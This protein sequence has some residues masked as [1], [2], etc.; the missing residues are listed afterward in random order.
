MRK[1]KII[2]I[3]ILIIMIV[4]T[5]VCIGLNIIYRKNIS[6][7]EV[8]T[9]SESFEYM[10]TFNDND[11]TPIV[12]YNDNDNNCTY[13]RIST[14]QFCYKPIDKNYNDNKIINPNELIS[15]IYYKN[16]NAKICLNM[17][18]YQKSDPIKSGELEGE[19]TI[20][21]DYNAD[22]VAIYIKLNNIT[23]SKIELNIENQRSVASPS[24]P[25]SLESIADDYYS[26]IY[27]KK[28]YFS[29]CSNNKY[30][31][32]DRYGKIVLDFI[33]DKEVQFNNECDLL[34]INKDG[35]DY[36]ADFSGKIISDGY[37][38]LDFI[39]NIDYYQAIYQEEIKKF[40]DYVIVS[41]L[42]NVDKNNTTSHENYNRKKFGL[43]NKEGKLI[44]P[45]LSGSYKYIFPEAKFCFVAL[46][47]S[48]YIITDYNGKQIGNNTYY[49]IRKDADGYYIAHLDIDCDFGKDVIINSNG[50]EI[51]DHYP[52][53]SIINSKLLLFK[54]GAAI[55]NT[56]IL[57][58]NFKIRM[59][60]ITIDRKEF[61]SEQP[62]MN[63][64]SSS[65]EFKIDGVTFRNLKG[66][67]RL[68][69]IDDDSIIIQCENDNIT[70]TITI[71]DGK[72]IEEL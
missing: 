51:S 48:K 7:Y 22:D 68:M 42:D 55:I 62:Y 69:H 65:E 37:E 14:Y 26:N 46:K 61:D 15:E 36:L 50:E 3:A 32:I 71:K 60:G 19:K 28:K 27:I 4:F 43:M 53:M 24:K 34:I 40:S 18:K 20:Y 59:E 54:S 35:L 10:Y 23:P 1:N 2:I 70:K 67:I 17:N 72:I 41:E 16:N 31:L 52:E 5:I 9:T 6:D 21:Q 63:R 33:S 47:G 38:K 58:K 11:E 57:D 39:N 66:K 29:L 30:G 8:Y 49:D 56:K 44:V 45:V 12:F 64:L 13:I 25:R